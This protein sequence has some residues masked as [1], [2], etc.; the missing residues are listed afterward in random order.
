MRGLC[1]SDFGSGVTP[2]DI[3]ASP[4]SPLPSPPPSLP[5]SFVVAVAEIGSFLNSGRRHCFRSDF[6]E[7][8]AICFVISIN[9][10]AI[11][12]RIFNH[13]TLGPHT[14]SKGLEQF[15]YPLASATSSMAIASGMP[16]HGP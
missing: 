9:R 10:A 5:V 8:S 13:R 7:P 3:C 14:M 12:K 16:E 15:R 1:R 11:S 4:A 2:Y 6:R